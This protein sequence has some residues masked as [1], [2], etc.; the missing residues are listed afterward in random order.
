MAMQL[1]ACFRI[2]HSGV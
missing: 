1:I 2:R